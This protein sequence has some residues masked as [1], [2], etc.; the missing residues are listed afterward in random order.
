MNLV[1]TCFCFRGFQCHEFFLLPSFV[2][3]CIKVL[4]DS[5]QNNRLHLQ[6]QQFRCYI[7]IC[8]CVCRQGGT[9]RTG[10]DVVA[11]RQ[12]FA[13]GY[14]GGWERFLS[15]VRLLSTGD[16]GIWEGFVEAR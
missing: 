14:V 12:V 1:S 7:P 10:D 13:D 3:V 15:I 6:K 5:E 2:K 11:F 4:P 16:R 9:S 8:F